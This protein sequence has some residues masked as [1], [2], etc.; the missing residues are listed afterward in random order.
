MLAAFGSIYEGRPSKPIILRIGM[1]TRQNLFVELI[2]LR[3]S[4]EFGV[5]LESRAHGDRVSCLAGI[6][7]V[8]N[9][10]SKAFRALPDSSTLTAVNDFLPC[11]FGG[12]LCWR[13][14]CSGKWHSQRFC[15]LEQDQ[16][17]L[18]HNCT[19]TTRVR[20]LFWFWYSL[21]RRF[22]FC[23]PSTVAARDPLGLSQSPSQ[24]SA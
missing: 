3:Y 11:M 21:R 20:G 14:T 2:P 5:S 9:T 13:K 19:G 17:H 22:D 4:G 16:V 6:S 12:A 23:H 1:H 15:F 24:A 10:Q 7:R 18:S 8:L